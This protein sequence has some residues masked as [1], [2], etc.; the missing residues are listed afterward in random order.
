MFALIASHGY[1][2]AAGQMYNFFPVPSFD[3]EVNRATAF[4]EWCGT[5]LETA[6]KVRGLHAGDVRMKVLVRHV[7]GAG[8][9]DG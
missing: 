3:E 7:C 4:L 6:A 5:N 8:A 2:V 1:I 9:A